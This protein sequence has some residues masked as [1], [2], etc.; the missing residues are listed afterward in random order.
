MNC[1]QVIGKD[2]KG[3][4]IYCKNPVRYE[5]S[6]ICVDHVWNHQK[7]G[8]RLTIKQM[9]ARLLEMAK[10]KPVKIV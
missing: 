3:E 5:G 6:F 9:Q 2:E 4:P 10:E 7:A 1:N 8:R